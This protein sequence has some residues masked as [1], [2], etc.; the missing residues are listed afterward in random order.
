LLGTTLRYPY[1]VRSATDAFDDI[2]D[3]KISGEML[4]LAEHILETKSGDFDPSKFEDHY[5]NALVEMLRQKQ[6]GFK[7]PKGKEKPAAPNVVN[8][9]DA[10]RQSIAAGR[11]TPAVEKAAPAAK[12]SA[13]PAKKGRK[14]AE[15]QREMLLPIE[16]RKQK[17]AAKKVA[18]K[19]A[20]RQ[21]KAG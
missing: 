11:R 20:G 13:A 1:E 17:E 16:G 6:A 19:P 18:A 7:P 8:L 21:R 12:A 4:K 3:I 5:E 10:L 14:K 9:M 15:G 2:S